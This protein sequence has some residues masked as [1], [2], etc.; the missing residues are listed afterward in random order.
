MK[1]NGTASNVLFPY[2]VEKRNG[3]AT[4]YR[5]EKVKNGRA[6]PEFRVATFTEDGKTQLVSF[7]SFD[8]ALKE[9]EA[10]I[11]ALGRGLVEVTTLSGPSRLDYLAAVQKL[12]PGVTLSE[13]ADAWLRSAQGP[14]IA[15][16]RVGDLVS[17]FIAS[18]ERTTRMG[19]PASAEYARDIERRLGK[20]AE[21]F[22]ADNAD[23]LTAA[24]LEAWIDATGQKGRHRFNTLRLVRTLLKWG[25]KRGHLPEGKL[26]TDKLEI[27]APVDDAAIGIF[28]PQELARLFAVAKEDMIP[29]L[30]LGAFAG[31]RTAE[32]QR[33]D[34]AA[35][36][37]ERGFVEVGADKAKT[38]SRRLVPVLP[39]LKAW[40]EPIRKTSGPVVPFA[41]VA[42]QIGWI[43]RDSKVAWKHNGLRHSFVSYRLASTQSPEQTAFEAGNSPAMVFKHYRELVT[44]KEAE[45]WFGVLPEVP[46][47][48]LAT[49]KQ[50][51][52]CP[53]E[54]TACT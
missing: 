34:W 21:A 42:K 40:L 49:E 18:R 43:A 15:P 17:A 24:R 12:P 16:I 10:R 32:I 27:V 51:S 31:L 37:L 39:A 13:A 29:F 48:V 4:I 9:A 28:T 50:V 5:R 6:Y 35:L 23:A 44:P 19:R 22:P 20:L 53:P 46:S 30:A 33:L 7:A 1:A 8:D 47:N 52:V 26:P 45:A 38:K 2:V 36:K 54:T 41:N 14:Q 3:R 25:Q 11:A